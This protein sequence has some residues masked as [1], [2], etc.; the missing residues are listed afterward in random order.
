ML[1]VV[2]FIIIGA[3][4]E[5]PWWYYLL[6]GIHL[7]ICFLRFEIASLKKGRDDD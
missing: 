3:W 5:A 6:C 1:A 4:L 2:L 7:F